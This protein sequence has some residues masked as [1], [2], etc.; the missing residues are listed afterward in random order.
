M[1]ALSGDRRTKWRRTEGGVGRANSLYMVS[2]PAKEPRF[3]QNSFAPRNLDRR[4]SVS[5][6]GGASVGK[7]ET[8]AAAVLLAPTVL[9]LFGYRSFLARQ[10]GRL[11]VHYGHFNLPQQVHY[12]L[13][14]TLHKFCDPGL[15]A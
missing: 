15:I 12:L 11:P 5:Q 10:W 8:P 3:E 4:G 14:E 2:F 6:A 1:Q 7:G 13:R 9:A